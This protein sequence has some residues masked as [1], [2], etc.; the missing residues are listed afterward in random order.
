MKLAL[1]FLMVVTIIRLGVAICTTESA[2][3]SVV[4]PYK[5]GMP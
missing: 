5:E 4:R 1:G 3:R 2:V